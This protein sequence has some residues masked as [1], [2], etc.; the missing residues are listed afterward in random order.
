MGC[1]VSRPSSTRL[2]WR[3]SSSRERYRIHR[4][5]LSARPLN[6]LWSSLRRHSNVLVSFC[7]PE[8]KTHL[9]VRDVGDELS[10]GPHIGCWPKIVVL[11]RHSIGRFEKITLSDCIE[12]LQFG[13]EGIRRLPKSVRRS[14]QATYHHPNSVARGS[15][16]VDGSNI[17]KGRKACPSGLSAVICLIWRVAA[18]GIDLAD[19]ASRRSRDTA[20]RTLRFQRAATTIPSGDG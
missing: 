16:R 20:I 5:T 19:R 18:I 3:R 12:L 6:R 7:S 14:E 2:Q 17:T 9:G 13:N 11:G 4:R 15:P 10:E 1:S 8:Q